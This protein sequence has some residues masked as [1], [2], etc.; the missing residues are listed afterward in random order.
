MKQLIFAV[1]DSKAKVFAIPFFLPSEAV[2]VRAFAAAAND[3]DTQLGKFPED[4]TLFQ[5]G[6]YND[7]NGQIFGL[8]PFKNLGL[9]AQFKRS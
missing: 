7:E 9:G 4:F 2:A 6:S 5:V 3:L 1:Y 8:E